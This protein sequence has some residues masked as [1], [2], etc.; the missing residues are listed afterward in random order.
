MCNQA[1]ILKLSFGTATGS[2]GR[3]DQ[4]TKSVAEADAHLPNVGAMSGVHFRMAERT[5]LSALCALI[6]TANRADDI[7]QVLD[8]AELTED[9]DDAGDLTVDVQLAIIGSELVGYVRTL[10]FPSDELW[11]RCY[12]IGAV[13]PQHRGRGIG[14]DLMTWATNRGTDLLRS[15]TNDLPKYLRVEVSEHG[16]VAR[17]LFHRFGFRE[18]RQFEELLRPLTE[19]PPVNDLDGVRIVSWPDDRDTEILEVKNVAFADHWGSTPTPAH[20]WNTW[21]RGVGGYPEQSFI[22]LDETD[23]VVAYSLNQRYAAD[24]ELL[25]RRD[26][27]IDNLG[28]LPEWRCRGLASALIVRSLHA[29]AAAGLTH[30]S[31]GVDSDS[32]TGA[33]RLYKSLGFAVNRRHDTLEIELPR[34]TDA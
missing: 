26:G 3:R 5:D 8:L 15:S 24:D 1:R 28:T 10:H 34:A 31:I 9:L 16:A 29:F 33:V 7:P 6:N 11:E 17:H 21:V 4:T 19:L 18:V 25:G 30:A 22:A 13:D 27:W 32:L 14:H 2:Q 20:K 23:R 12:L